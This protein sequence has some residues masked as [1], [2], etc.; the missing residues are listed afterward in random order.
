MCRLH[1]N[2]LVPANLTKPYEFPVFDIILH[3]NAHK[4]Q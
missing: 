3:T 4:K 2:Q 1:A